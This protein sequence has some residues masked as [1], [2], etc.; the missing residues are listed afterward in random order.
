MRRD[1]LFVTA[2]M[3]LVLGAAAAY[4][5]DKEA[6]VKTATESGD[7]EVTSSELAQDWIGREIPGADLVDRKVRVDPLQHV[8]VPHRSQISH[9]RASAH[10][11]ELEMLFALKLE[12]LEVAVPVR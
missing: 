2:S 9:A 11:C 4:G 5:A 12:S 3:L 7:F 8:E 1:K 6:F 10:F